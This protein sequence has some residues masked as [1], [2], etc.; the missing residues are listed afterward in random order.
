MAG[1]KRKIDEITS[2][3]D[4]DNQTN[5][6]QVPDPDT[7]LIGKRPRL[8]IAGTAGQGPAMPA[9]VGSKFGIGEALGSG[10]PPAK[11]GEGKGKRRLEQVNTDDE[12]DGEGEDEDNNGEGEEE[13]VETPADNRKVTAGP[14]RKAAPPK[15]QPRRRRR[16]DPE[17]DYS[18]TMRLKMKST[19]RTGQA[20]DRCRVSG[21]APSH[22]SLAHLEASK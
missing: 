16:G 22:D 13:E 21:S 8:L 6:A 11:K 7:G 1:Q 5:R 10:D 3:S 14:S 18:E 9:V 4:N 12:E 17:P 2:P 20:C 19:K 15:K